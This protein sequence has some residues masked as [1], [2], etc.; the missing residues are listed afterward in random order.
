[1]NYINDKGIEPT[2][3]LKGALS[4][5]SAFEFFMKKCKLDVQK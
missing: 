3:D 2:A 5:G 1:M 4:M